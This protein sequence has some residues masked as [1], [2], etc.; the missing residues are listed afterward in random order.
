M[1]SVSV[2]AFSVAREAGMTVKKSNMPNTERAESFF[3]IDWD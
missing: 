3:C 1:P 2:T